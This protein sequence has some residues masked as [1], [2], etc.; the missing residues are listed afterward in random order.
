[1]KIVYLSGIDGCGKTTQAKLLVEALRK[2][3]VNAE[4]FWL[5][6]EPSFKKISNHIRSFVSNFYSKNRKKPSKVDENQDNNQDKWLFLK[7]KMLS[8]LFIR[9]LWLVLSSADY[10]FAYK[11][12]FKKMTADVAVVDRYIND[13]IIDQAINSG[14]DP[15]RINK[16]KRAYFLNKFRF[17]DYTIII[18][19]PASEGYSRKNDGTSQDY[20]EVRQRYYKSIN[21]QNTLHLNGL[22]SIDVLHDKVKTWV[23]QQ[24]GRKNA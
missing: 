9:K 1:M 3:G 17:P 6:W 5:R 19:L 23:F 7:R 18:N 13:F 4:Y 20:L 21:G 11:K 24:I 10:Y 16:I 8:N 12:C 2:K 14:V 22:E 15:E